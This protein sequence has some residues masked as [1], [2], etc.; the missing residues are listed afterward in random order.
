VHY[1]TKTNSRILQTNQNRIWVEPKE[2]SNMLIL[3]RKQNEKIHIGNEITVHVLNIRKGGVQLGITAP[4]EVA[5]VR[6]E[7][8]HT[9]TDENETIKRVAAAESGRAV[10]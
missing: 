3:A 5:I 6:D 7:L 10:R 8:T 9:S 2:N 1:S 4:K